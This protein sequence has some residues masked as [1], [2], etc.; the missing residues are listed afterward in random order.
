[1]T[2][3]CWHVG[4]SI[5]TDILDLRR[6]PFPTS[7]SSHQIVQSFQSG[8]NSHADLKYTLQLGKGDPS[9]HSSPPS[10]ISRRCISPFAKC[11]SVKT[12]ISWKI[13]RYTTNFLFLEQE[14]WPL[15]LQPM[16]PSV[17]STPKARAMAVTMIEVNFI[18]KSS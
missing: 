16:G 13:V 5:E 12:V 17:A 11:R 9:H 10:S 1:M 2:T 6:H 4:Y 15:L 18:V 3:P 8:G 14:S 7:P